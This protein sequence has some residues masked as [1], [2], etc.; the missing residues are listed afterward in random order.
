[1]DNKNIKRKDLLHIVT[2][3]HT[4]FAEVLPENRL[5]K[6]LAITVVGAIDR[7]FTCEGVHGLSRAKTMSNCFVRH[8]M[9]T[10]LEQVP[11]SNRYKRLIQKALLL[12]TCTRSK[13]YWVSVFSA[14]R[15]FY[16]EPAVD[17]ST[18]I[19]G[20]E[21]RLTGLLKWKYF[22]AWSKTNTSFRSVID[23]NW[24]ATF[25][26]H[27][28]G[29]SGPNGRLG[30][31]QYLNDLR[32]LSNSRLLIGLFILL[33]SLPYVNKRETV[34]A[35][36]DAFIDSLTKGEENS[37]HSR[38]HFLSDKG[39][40]TRV[41]AVGDILSQSFLHTVHQRCN[42][43][44]RRLIQDGTFDQDRS[45]LYIQKMSGKN[46]PLASIDL[47][48]ATD[49][50]PALFQ[51]FVIVSLR[52]L[53]PLQALAWWWVTTRRTF[54]YT[55]KGI[56]KCTRYTVGQPMGLLS[57]WPVM[58]ISHHYLVRFS[59]AVSGHKRL[60]K[61]PYS[62]LGDDLSLKGFGVAGEYLELIACL[63]MQYS[64]EKTY[65][66]KGV[67]EF[68]KSLFCLGKDLTPFPLALLRFNRNTV[69]SNTLA[70]VTECK[71]R[72]LLLTS[73]TLTGIHPKRWRNLVLLAALSP[74]SPRLGL[75]LHARPDQWI[76]LQFA[77][78]KRLQYF[79]RLNTVRISTHAF[80]IN[81]P[82]TSGKK[83][84]SP[85]LQIGADNS[86]SYPVRHLGDEYFPLMM[87]G[88]GWISYS[89]LAFPNGLPPLGD[90]TLVP[91][92]V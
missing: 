88:Q 39:G 80:A 78:C 13:I 55:D 62:L 91:G 42:L 25:K 71:K 89:T 12:C 54:V 45:R 64:P 17:I 53:T 59:F 77:Y 83:L 26:W 10:P 35:L 19:G 76:F 33:T 73:A 5:D 85:F 27:I 29:A 63:G 6:Q 51:V 15:L 47:K 21:G 38:L 75:D 70:I 40:K 48:S 16:A 3:L 44:L 30:Y 82:G 34:K 61:A 24:S 74:S 1:M 87:L 56:L 49:R 57:S 20:F 67:A 43:I 92:P 28:S 22:T 50:M 36:R 23:Q 32:A 90:R 46:F 52:I 84:G 69:V 68:A 2:K 79:G 7:W 86:E 65:I 4:L 11:L 31:T 60:E 14:F 66:A 81:D 18:V 37:I 58:A 72:N 41:I 8:V 9:G